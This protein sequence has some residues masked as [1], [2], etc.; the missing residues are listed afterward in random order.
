MKRASV[1]FSPL[2]AAAILVMFSTLTGCS[3][4]EQAKTYPVSGTVTLDGS[5][6]VGATVMLQPI[7]GG[8]FGFGETDS[9]G[10]F[11]ISTFAVGDGA[12]PGEHRIVV[13]KKAAAAELAPAGDGD[14]EPQ[15]DENPSDSQRVPKRYSNAETSGL[16][17]LVEDGVEPLVLKLSGIE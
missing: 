5:P 7:E 8:S 13:S 17:V 10:L 9:K 16:K 1:W 6:L 14:N 2:A 12:I 11:V 15:T 3:S 4:K